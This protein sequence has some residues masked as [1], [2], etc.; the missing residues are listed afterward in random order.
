MF[1]FVQPHFSELNVQL[2]TCMKPPRPWRLN[3][4]ILILLNRQ[5]IV[6]ATFFCAF[7]QISQTRETKERL[8]TNNYS[9]RVCPKQWSKQSISRVSAVVGL[10]FAGRALF[11]LV[12]QSLCA[13]RPGGLTSKCTGRTTGACSSSQTALH[14]YS[15]LTL[16]GN[17]LWENKCI[18]QE[19][20]ILHPPLELPWCFCMHGSHRPV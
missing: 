20:E 9:L 18:S 11:S 14:T 16:S 2:C 4:A 17:G 6:H 1:Y 19:R 10:L 8:K 15:C 3:A 12:L 13:A 5:F 7:W